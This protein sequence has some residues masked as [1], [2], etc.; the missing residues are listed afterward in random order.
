MGR[1]SSLLPCARL[2]LTTC[3]WQVVHGGRGAEAPQTAGESQE[4]LTLVPAAIGTQARVLT[5]ANG[6]HT[7]QHS[8][9]QVRRRSCDVRMQLDC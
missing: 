4:A 3:T 8:L 7:S 1:Q 2:D 5:E 9:S 6:I